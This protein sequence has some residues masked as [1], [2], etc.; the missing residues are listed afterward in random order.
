VRDTQRLIRCD[1]LEREHLARFKRQRRQSLS[2]EAL[3]A[4]CFVWLRAACLPTVAVTFGS[5]T[6]LRRA[7]AFSI[8]K[9]SKRLSIFLVLPDFD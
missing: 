7:R 5:V 3:A 8:S 1:L 6:G 2:R 9:R 4:F